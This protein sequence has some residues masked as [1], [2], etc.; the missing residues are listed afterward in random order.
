[1]AKLP[2]VT[3]REMVGALHRGGWV[4]VRQTGSHIQLQHSD[5][6]GAVTVPM[7]AGTMDPGLARSILNQARM[8]DD[9]LRR[10]L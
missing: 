7:H 3:A 6:P 1:M 8:T 2:R 10:L 9:E 4:T 5:R